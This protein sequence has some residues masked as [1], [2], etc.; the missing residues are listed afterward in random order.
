MEASLKWPQVI[1]GARARGNFAAVD[2][3]KLA[4]SGVLLWLV[5]LRVGDGGFWNS[6]RMSWKI[7]CSEDKA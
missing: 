7:Y 2:L 5:V 6:W 4:V 3:V 1:A